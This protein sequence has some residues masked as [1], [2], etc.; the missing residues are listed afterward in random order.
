MRRKHKVWSTRVKKKWCGWLLS[1]RTPAVIEPAMK[2]L[3]QT[4]SVLKSQ[5][6]V[7]MRF[8][9]VVQIKTGQHFFTTMWRNVSCAKKKNV[10]WVPSLFEFFLFIFTFCGLND[11]SLECDVL[12]KTLERKIIVLCFSLDAVRERSNIFRLPYYIIWLYCY[13]FM[14]AGILMH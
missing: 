9:S 12:W 4:P 5:R 3:I 7:T 10:A 1:L 11:D 6:L 8:S 14:S 2:G 13:I